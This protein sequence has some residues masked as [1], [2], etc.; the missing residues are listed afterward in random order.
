[1]PL[2]AWGLMGKY[3]EGGG[4]KGEKRGRPFLRRLEDVRVKGGGAGERTI[5]VMVAEWG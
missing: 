2:F 3:W 4:L 1:M 5:S